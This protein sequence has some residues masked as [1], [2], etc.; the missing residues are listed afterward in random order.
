MPNCRC[1]K[2]PGGGVS[3]KMN[4][5]KSGSFMP[6][7]KRK[8]AGK[9]LILQNSAQ[10][11]PNPQVEGF[12]PESK[13]FYQGKGLKSDMQKITEKLDKLNMVKPKNVKKNIRVNL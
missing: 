4:K 10:F 9:G 8:L 5:G 12:S 11:Q 7:I 13:T 6:L 1:M 3:L 2:T